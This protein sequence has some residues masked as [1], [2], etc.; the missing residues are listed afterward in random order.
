MAFRLQEFLANVRELARAY[1]F[2]AELIFP[3]VIGSSA[4][5]NIL[6]ESTEIPSYNIAPVPSNYAGQPL[7]LAGFV[8][9][10]TWSCTLRI[11]DN[12]DV[13]KQFRAWNEL[14]VGT[15]TNIA[16][17]PSQYKSS[18]KLYQLDNA[19]NKLISWQFFGAWVSNLEDIT[20]AYNNKDINT[21]KIDFEY[22]YN[23]LIVES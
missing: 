5:V 16:A 6:V 13:Y 23:Y 3:V 10:P 14:V 21:L 18:F 11:D 20:L 8:K 4:L 22:D 12:Y 9:F 19:G 17:F 1:Q 15:L 2:E 7:N